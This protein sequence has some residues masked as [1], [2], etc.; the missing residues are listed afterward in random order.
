MAERNYLYF[1]VKNPTLY[2]RKLALQ[3]SS[4]HTA[5]EAENLVFFKY[6]SATKIEK[7]VDFTKIPACAGE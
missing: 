1:L 2:S 4:R 7:Q 5:V 6:I 3:A